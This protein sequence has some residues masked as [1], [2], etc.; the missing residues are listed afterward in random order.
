VPDN[1]PDACPIFAEQQFVDGEYALE[2][3][4]VPEPC[5]PDTQKVHDE[6][7]LYLEGE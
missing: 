5:L 7:A 3:H 4:L 6:M 1:G 2:D